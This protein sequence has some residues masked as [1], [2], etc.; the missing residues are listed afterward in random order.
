MK[1]RNLKIVY[2]D[3]PED[4]DPNQTEYFYLYKKDGSRIEFVDKDFIQILQDKYDFSNNKDNYIITKQY[5]DES[6]HWVQVEYEI[7]V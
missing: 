4:D 7:K 5:R 1:R 3:N 2:I 6:N